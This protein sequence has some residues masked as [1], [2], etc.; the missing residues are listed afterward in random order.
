MKDG[1]PKRLGEVGLANF[2]P[3]LMNR[4]MGRYNAG[5]REELADLGLTTPKARALAAM[6]PTAHAAFPD[7]PITL[8]VPFPA[9]GPNDIIARLVTLRM[10]QELGQPMVVENKGGAGGAIGASEAARADADG[11]TLSIGHWS[12]HVINGAIYPLQ[13]DLLKDLQPLALIASNPLLV[14]ASA[15]NPADELTVPGADHFFHRRL[16]LIRDIV[17]RAWRH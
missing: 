4:I 12:T 11:Y 2:A 16:H 17:T 9:G 5:F 3:Y 10:S 13:Y 14:V 8:I 1:V 15:G 6:L 7:R